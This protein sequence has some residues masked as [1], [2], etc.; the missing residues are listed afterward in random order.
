MEE[1][2][3]GGPADVADHLPDARVAGRRERKRVIITR[4][5]RAV[6]IAHGSHAGDRQLDDSL[7]CY[8]DVDIAGASG[9]VRGFT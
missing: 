3:A 5:Y 6:N 2:V 4:V 7:L 1:N 8:A 9:F